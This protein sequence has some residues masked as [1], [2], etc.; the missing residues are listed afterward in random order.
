M[1]VKVVKAGTLPP[2]PRFCP[3]S[4]G[5]ARKSDGKEG[6]VG[7]FLD[8]PGPLSMAESW[9]RAR[10]RLSKGCQG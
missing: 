3:K 8:G 10:D 6:K 7:L 5:K 4:D 9:C 1:I 2:G